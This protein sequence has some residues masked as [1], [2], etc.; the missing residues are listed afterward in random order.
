MIYLIVKLDCSTQVL[1]LIY[2]K[3]IKLEFFGNDIY[4]YK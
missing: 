1:P 4:V 2:K 3:G